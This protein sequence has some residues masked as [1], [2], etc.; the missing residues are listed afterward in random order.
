M[1]IVQTATET[2]GTCI[3]TGRSDGPFVQLDRL[4]ED[5]TGTTYVRV[6]AVEEMAREIGMVPQAEQLT[7]SE[8]AT[9]EAR[10]EAAEAAHNELLAA[11][12][13]TLKHGAVIRRGAISLRKPYDHARRK[14]AAQK[15]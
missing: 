3:L 12:A 7:E 14:H 8:R 13:T 5:G 15:P 1:R 9:L 11:V 2:P 4:R 10:A 6:A